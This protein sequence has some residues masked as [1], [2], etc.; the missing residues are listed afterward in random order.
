[1]K[2]SMNRILMGALVIAAV[3]A[4]SAP[5]SASYSFD[6]F[7]VKEMI[8]GTVQGDVF[9]SYGDH[10]G[11]PT[12][13]TSPPQVYR[14]NYSV[15]VGTAVSW[16]RLYVGIWGGTELRTGW[17]NTT[18]SGTSLG[19]VTLDGNT[20]SNPTYSS[21][22][23]AYNTG[24]GVWMVSYN[25]TNNVTLGE[26]NRAVATV[27]GGVDGRVYGIVLVVVYEN[28]SLPKVQYWVNEGN[29]N[30]NYVTPLNN[31]VS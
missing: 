9:V 23:N 18:L 3:L 27:G 25:C 31:N 28:T 7:E 2:M 30:L 10:A 22:T 1:M 12:S 20:D 6:G 19:N 21:G 15:P 14:T 17:V 26:T 29:V 13:R 8:N 11:L 24:N 16:A 5:A 4:F